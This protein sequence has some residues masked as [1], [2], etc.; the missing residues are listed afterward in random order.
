M[1]NQFEPGLRR[2]LWEFRDYLPDIVVGGGWVPYL[3]QRYGGFTQWTSAISLTGEVDVLVGETTQGNSRRPLHDLLVANDFEPVNGTDLAAWAKDPRVGEKIEFLIVNNGPH[4][5]E[6]SRRSVPG[7]AGVSAI[8]LDDLQIL[9]RHTGSLTAPIPVAGSTEQSLT[10]RVPILGAYVV[11]KALTFNKRLP[12]IE[13]GVAVENPKRAKDL[14]YLHDV[15]AG[16]TEVIAQ[17]E[18]D[19][20]SMCEDQRSS[21]LVS[22]AAGQV[23]IVLRERA[24]ALAKCETMLVERDGLSKREAAAR[25]EGYLTEVAELLDGAAD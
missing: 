22:Q 19:V 24:V 1:S 15:F 4:A 21:M 16:G 8:A 6:G 20:Q 11:N 25:I 12:Q 7:Q 13:N 10:I 14:L 3:Y 17:V 18:S 9:E 23:R 2:I 5:W